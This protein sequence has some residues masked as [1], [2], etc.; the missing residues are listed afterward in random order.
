MKACVLS[1]YN[2]DALEITKGILASFGCELMINTVVPCDLIICPDYEKKLTHTEIGL[3]RLGAFVFHPSL[4][5]AYKGK[6]CIKAQYKAGETKGGAS[7]FIATDK[8][9][10]GPV[11][12]SG[13]ASINTEIPPKIYYK[14]SILPLLSDGLKHLLHEAVH[15]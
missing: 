6:G 8:F 11:V 5:P 15:A 14:N 4:L 1:S 2:S 7:W 12:W 13:A 3:S 9:D 10:S